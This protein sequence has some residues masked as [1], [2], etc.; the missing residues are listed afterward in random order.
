MLKHTLPAV[1]LAACFLTASCSDTETSAVA[2]SPSPLFTNGSFASITPSTLTAQRNSRF[3]CPG[4][5]PLVVSANLVVL[6]DDDPPLF[7]NEVRLRFTD[8]AGV[9]G[10][11][12]TLPAPLPTTQHG[13]ALVQAR[14][15][16]QFPLIFGFGCGTD[17]TGF[18][19]VNVLARDGRGRNRS[20]E[21]RVNVR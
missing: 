8:R 16:R 12:V 1:L 10:P 5:Q 15:S 3:G 2:T 13:T 17:S 6:D 18:L 19:T 21:I 11:Q 4:V 9:P 7:I 14:S 20:A